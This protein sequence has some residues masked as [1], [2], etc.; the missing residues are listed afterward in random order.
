MGTVLTAGEETNPDKSRQPHV[1][2]IHTYI[3]TYSMLRCS[4]SV[5]LGV[6]RELAAN[7]SR[8]KPIYEKAVLRGVA[9]RQTWWCAE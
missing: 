3:H 8:T 9:E 6:F 4:L 7:A 5:L 1:T 2:Y